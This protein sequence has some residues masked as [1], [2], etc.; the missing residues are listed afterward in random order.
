MARDLHIQLYM[1]KR[2]PPLDQRGTSTHLRQTCISKATEAN[3]GKIIMNTA[4]ASK[5]RSFVQPIIINTP[6]K[7]TTG[8]KNS[9]K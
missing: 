7:N 9:S 5:L 1:H 4:P 6:P 3:T 8:A 2:T